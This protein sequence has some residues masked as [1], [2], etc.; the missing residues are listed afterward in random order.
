MPATKNAGFHGVLHGKTV[1][2]II[3]GIHHKLSGALEQSVTIA[4]QIPELKRFSERFIFRGKGFNGLQG[5]LIDNSAVLEIDNDKFG[6]IQRIKNFRKTV[7]RSKN[8]GPS[9]S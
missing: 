3:I 9:I 4:G 7:R 8:S 6:I 2:W 5:G 1:I